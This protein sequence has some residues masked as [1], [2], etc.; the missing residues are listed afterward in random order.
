MNDNEQSCCRTQS[1]EQETRFFLGMF[2]I[3][4]NARVRIAENALRLFK[5]NSMLRPIALVLSLVPIE[6]QYI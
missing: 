3:M 6:P 4:E 2:W 1:E 5:P